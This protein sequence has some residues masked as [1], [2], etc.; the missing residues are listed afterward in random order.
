M[1]KLND[2][3]HVAIPDCDCRAFHLVDQHRMKLWT[4]ELQD[5]EAS[6]GVMLIS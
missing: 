1:I 6:V 3:R 2:G 5:I 4:E